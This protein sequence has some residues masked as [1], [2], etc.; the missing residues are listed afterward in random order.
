MA[1]LCQPPDRLVGAVTTSHHQGH[2]PSPVRWYLVLLSTLF[3]LQEYA[4]LTGAGRTHT[5][6]ELRPLFL[7]GKGQR[8]FS[9]S[10][11]L[12]HFRV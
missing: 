3:P 7:N 6:L 12:I 8:H 10:S 11:S 5:D 1:A 9:G 2:Q 4:S